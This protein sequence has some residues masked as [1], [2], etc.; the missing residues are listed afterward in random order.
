M[1]LRIK[2]LVKKSILKNLSWKFGCTYSSYYF[3]TMKLN[4]NS[5]LYILHL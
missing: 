5:D 2:A 3:G 1:V 4:K